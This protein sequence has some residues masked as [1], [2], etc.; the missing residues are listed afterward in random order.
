MSELC[1]HVM[2]TKPTRKQAK[3]IERIVI[4]EGGWAFKV[5][6]VTQGD[7]PWCNNGHYQGWCTGPNRG[8]P[9]D[10]EL[11]ARVAER[12]AKEVLYNLNARE[13]G[14]DID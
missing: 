12:I 4:D 6:N 2:H 10:Q 9:W 7:E 8:A 5:L 14:D 13:T 11:A 3:R 1:F